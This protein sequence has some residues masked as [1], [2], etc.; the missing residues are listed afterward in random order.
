M[1]A[2]NPSPVVLSC[3]ALSVVIFQRC[4]EALVQSPRGEDRGDDRHE[5]DE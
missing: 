3:S 4:M 5:G 2:V 1:N